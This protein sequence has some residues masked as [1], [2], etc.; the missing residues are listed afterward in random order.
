MEKELE[1]LRD[2]IDTA[3]SYLLTIK[4]IDKDTLIDILLND[5]E[6]VKI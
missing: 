3:I 2:N 5:K 1:I 4:D 6:Y